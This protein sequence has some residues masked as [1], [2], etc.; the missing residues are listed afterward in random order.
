MSEGEQRNAVLGRLTCLLTPGLAAAP[1]AEVMS[2]LCVLRG[3][4]WNDSVA[5]IALLYSSGLR[6]VKIFVHLC[7]R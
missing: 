3:R 2:F 1:H 7:I 4:V 6:T 5:K